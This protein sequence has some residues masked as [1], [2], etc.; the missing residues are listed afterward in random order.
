MKALWPSRA[1]GFILQVKASIL[2]N[3]EN[4]LFFFFFCP[5]FAIS[6]TQQ[7]A[8]WELPGTEGLSGIGPPRERKGDSASREPLANIPDVSRSLLLD[9]FFTLKWFEGEGLK[10]KW[11]KMERLW[12]NHG[13]C[14]PSNKGRFY[15]NSILVSHDSLCI[16]YYM[17]IYIKSPR[18]LVQCRFLSSTQRTGMGRELSLLITLLK[19]SPWMGLGKYWRNGPHTILPIMG[20]KISISMSIFIYLFIERAEWIF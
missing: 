3:R 11:D 14:S 9:C 17:T 15:S 5:G 16:I 18:E 19:I 10:E 20:S 6:L 12:Y 2:S 8:T 4:I 7:V 13:S 1:T